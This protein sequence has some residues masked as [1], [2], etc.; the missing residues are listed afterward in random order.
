MRALFVGLPKTY[1][2]TPKNNVAPRLGF[3]YDVFGNGKTAIRG[4][5]GIFFMRENTFSY[6][7]DTS[8][9]PFNSA[10]SISNGNIANPGGVAGTVNPVSPVHLRTELQAGLCAESRSLGFQQQLPK[11]MILEMN[12]VGNQ[13]LHMP[14]LINLNQLQ[15]GTTISTTGATNNAEH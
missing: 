3:A 2:N 10:L 13:V 1:N 11:Q 9:L 8:N 7:T 5:Y 4:S 12:Y 14:M 6:Q 15:Q